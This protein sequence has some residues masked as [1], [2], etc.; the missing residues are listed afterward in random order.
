[1]RPLADVVVPIR[2]RIKPGAASETPQAPPDRARI[3]AEFW[4]SNKDEALA[5]QRKEAN[6]A[7]HLAA[8]LSDKVRAKIAEYLSRHPDA[9]SNAIARWLKGDPEM[10]P[11]VAHLKLSS[12]APKISLLRK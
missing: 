6:E 4:L 7:R 10:A 3:A 2:A 8:Q 11:L 1:M 5:Q 12:L 9:S